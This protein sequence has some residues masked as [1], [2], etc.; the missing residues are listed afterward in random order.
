MDN[1]TPPAKLMMGPF[2]VVTFQWRSCDGRYH[3]YLY[4]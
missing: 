4:R 1:P 3:L 2:S